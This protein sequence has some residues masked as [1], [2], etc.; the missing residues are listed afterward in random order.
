[1]HRVSIRRAIDAG[2]RSR[3]LAATVRATLDWY[4][5][6]PEDKPFRWGGGMPA[7]REAQV[8]AAWHEFE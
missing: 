4:H 1:M 3:P 6:W 7:E 5:A 2:L 8:L